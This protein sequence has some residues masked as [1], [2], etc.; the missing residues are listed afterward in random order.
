MRA[1]Q[2]VAW[3][4]GA[5]VLAILLVPPVAAVTRRLRPVQVRRVRP[6]STAW[7]LP[8]TTAVVLLAMPAAVAEFDYRYVLPAVPAACLAAALAMSKP[9]FTNIPINVRI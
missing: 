6:A 4:P 2:R 9:S 8:W 3:L 7:V 1:Y 5:A